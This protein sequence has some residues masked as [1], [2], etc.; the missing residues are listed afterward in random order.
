MEC[1]RKRDYLQNFFMA[2]GMFNGILENMV[3]G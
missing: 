1:D 2:F 3:T